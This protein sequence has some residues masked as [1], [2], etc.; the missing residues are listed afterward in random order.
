[1]RVECQRLPVFK[2][3]RIQQPKGSSSRLDSATLMWWIRSKTMKKREKTESVTKT[4]RGNMTDRYIRTQVVT[5]RRVNLFQDR[6]SSK[7]YSVGKK[8]T[9]IA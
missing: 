1:M 3:G 4:G 9:T 6:K 7:E 5:Q 2:P 8:E